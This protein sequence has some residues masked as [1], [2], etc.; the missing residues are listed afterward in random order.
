MPRRNTDAGAQLSA[1]TT[2]EDIL[3][4]SCGAGAG[5]IAQVFNLLSPCCWIPKQRGT[6]LW[7]NKICMV[8]Y[9]RAVA[10]TKTEKSGNKDF[11][12][13]LIIISQK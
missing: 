2:E 10:S 4:N 12:F 1:R 11:K 8:L 7:L 13:Y 3:R 5:H 9:G 6:I